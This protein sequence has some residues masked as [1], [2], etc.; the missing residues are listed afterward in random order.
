MR[1]LDDLRVAQTLKQRRDL[2][3]S[4]IVVPENCESCVKTRHLEV[5]LEDYVV[6]ADES[7]FSCDGL[8]FK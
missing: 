8:P 7:A 2:D 4:D 3:Q 6:L 5:V 1:Y